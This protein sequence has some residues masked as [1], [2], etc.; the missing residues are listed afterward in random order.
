MK[1]IL[2]PVCVV[3]SLCVCGC[4]SQADKMAEFCLGF[5][6]A[7]QGSSECAEMAKKLTEHLDAVQP[8]LNDHDLCTET[9]ACLPCRKGVRDMLTRCGHDPAL[10]PVFDRLHFS[11]TLRAVAED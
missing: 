2:L 8:K 5:D 11:K 7:V 4:R 10:R 9:T 6:E 3:C 1:R